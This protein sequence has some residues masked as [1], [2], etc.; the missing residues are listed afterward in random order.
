MDRCKINGYVETAYPYRKVV[1]EEPL[2]MRKLN[3]QTH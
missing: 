1:R 2:K 3:P